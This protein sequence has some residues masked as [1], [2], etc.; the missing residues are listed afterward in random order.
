MRFAEILRRSQ[1]TGGP[2]ADWYTSS[3][4]SGSAE[5]NAPHLILLPIILAFASVG[6][7]V[8]GES[9]ARGDRIHEVGNP[10]CDVRTRGVARPDRPGHGDLE[11]RAGFH[12]VTDATIRSRPVHRRAGSTPATP[13]GNSSHPDSPGVFEYHRSFHH[14]YEGAHPVE[15]QATR[16]PHGG[17]GLTIRPPTPRIARRAETAARGNGG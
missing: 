1:Q 4:T 2:P 6:M 17:H 15:A 5:E 11:Q 8:S 3:C 14:R 13:A 7:L 12:T 16:T 10:L 9:P